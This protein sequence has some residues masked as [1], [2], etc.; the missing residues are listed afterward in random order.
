MQRTILSV[1]LVALFALALG[2]SAVDDVSAQG[3]PTGGCNTG[4]ELDSVAYIVQTLAPPAFA[5]TVRSSDGNRDGYLC[6]RISPAFV[7]TD[8][9]VP[10][11]QAPV[12]TPAH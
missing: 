11:N 10:L 12:K 8:N 1:V 4:F 6:A 2:L 9:T 3:P 5:D 7:Y